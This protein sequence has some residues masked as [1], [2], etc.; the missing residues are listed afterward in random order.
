MKMSVEMARKIALASGNMCDRVTVPQPPSTN[1]L[2]ITR[3][4]YRVTSPAY[5]AWQEQAIPLLAFLK[6]P[7]AYPVRFRALIRGKVHHARDWDNYVK[8][9]QDGAVKAGVLTGDTLRYV[10]GGPVDYEPGD[11]EPVVDVWFEPL[12]AEGV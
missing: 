12:D 6:S 3:G 4:K 11:Y 5:R 10:R 9:L 7:V 1:N 8:P 2:F